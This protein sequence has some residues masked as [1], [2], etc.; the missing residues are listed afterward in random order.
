[1][2]DRP[3]NN[4]DNNDAN[5][6]KY[7][8][9]RSVVSGTA[10]LSGVLTGFIAAENSIFPKPGLPI[11]IATAFVAWSGVYG[12][13]RLC[14]NNHSEAKS[15]ASV[16]ATAAF[17]STNVG[18]FAMRHFG[19][20]SLNDSSA[21]FARE[22]LVRSLRG[23]IVGVGLLGLSLPILLNQDV[24]NGYKKLKGNNLKEKAK[25]LL[26]N[27]RNDAAK[28]TPQSNEEVKDTNNSVLRKN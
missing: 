19:E 2:Q 20:I 1:M 26:F 16:A 15:F 27:K 7:I 14:T 23:T 18:W 21:T 11:S 3:S 28:L 8:I 10:S 4:T 22:S 9:L 6:T 24:Q 12:V 13:A 25:F 17:I 5:K